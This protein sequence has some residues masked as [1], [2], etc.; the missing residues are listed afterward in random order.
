MIELKKINKSKINCCSE[1]LLSNKKDTFYFHQL[2]WSPEQIK[3]QS[4]RDTNYSFGLW[5]SENI[6]G[7]IL[8]NLLSIEKKSE[9]EILLLYVDINFR[10]QGYASYLIDA[11]TQLLFLESTLSRII[12]EVSENNRSAINLY[13]KNDFH[14]IAKR[15]KY[16]NLSNGQSFDALIFEKKISE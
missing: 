14:Q 6:L 2:G 1:L 11:V 10:K 4:N 15:K 7:F 8:G 16:Y 13:K 3:L 12:L 5:K 9:Y